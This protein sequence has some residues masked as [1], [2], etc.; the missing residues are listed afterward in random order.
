VSKRK[1]REMEVL[2]HEN[3]LRTSIKL[4][5]DEKE[6]Y[7]LRVS[8]DEMRDAIWTARFYL[9]GS[10]DYYDVGKARRELNVI[11]GNGELVESPYEWMMT[12][13]ARG[14]HVGDCTCLPSS[15]GKCHAESVLG[16]DTIRGL[17]KHEA[18]R[19]QSLFGGYGGAP[20]RGISEVIQMLTE[21]IGQPF[22]KPEKWPDKVGWEKHIPRWTEETRRAL[23]WLTEYRDAHFSGVE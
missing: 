13:L 12:E 7:R 18:A 4:T 10:K 2:W 15:C 17:G 3:P 14:V 1:E 22:A 9:D 8:I 16:V 5:D 21:Q 19:L 11:D 20:E 23:R 6:V